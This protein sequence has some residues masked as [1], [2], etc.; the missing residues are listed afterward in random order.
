M[1]NTKLEQEIARELRLLKMVDPAAQAFDEIQRFIDSRKFERE[2]KRWPRWVKTALW[3][4]PVALMVLA[5]F[6]PPGDLPPW[7]LPVVWG[8]SFLTTYFL[9][10]VFSKDDDN[11]TF[12]W[13]R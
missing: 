9:I 13:A 4:T 6:P 2:F 1:G 3:H 12:H 5:A 11:N 10:S 8:T 7:A